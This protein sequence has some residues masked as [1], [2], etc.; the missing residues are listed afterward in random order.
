[1]F[2]FCSLFN[3]FFIIN[4]LDSV[5]FLVSFNLINESG[6]EYVW[7]SIVRV[8]INWL[9]YNCVGEIFIDSIKDCFIRFNFESVLKVCLSV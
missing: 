6:I 9:L 4:E 7:F 3:C 2:K 1:M 8:G 5:M